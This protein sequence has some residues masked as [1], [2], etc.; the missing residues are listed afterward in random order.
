[1]YVLS[2]KKEQDE[3]KKKGSVSAGWRHAAILAP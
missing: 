1:M 2:G 3:K